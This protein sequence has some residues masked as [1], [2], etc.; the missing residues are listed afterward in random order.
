M[1]RTQSKKVSEMSRGWKKYQYDYHL[2]GKRVRMYRSA[3]G[4]SFADLSL[5]TGINKGT[6]QQ[7]EGKG[8]S[9]PEDDRM[10]LVDVLSEALE[11]TTIRVDRREFLKLAGLGT[12]AILATATSMAPSERN[13]TPVLMRYGSICLELAES[14]IVDLQGE[15]YR[16]KAPDVLKEAQQWYSKLSRAGL[17]ETDPY[18]AAT[19]IRFGILLGRAQE[20]TLPWYQRCKAAIRTYDDVEERIIL[21]FPLNR[22]QVDYAR[23]L[24]LRAPMYRELGQFDESVDQ[25]KDGLSYTERIDNPFLKAALLRDSAHLRAVQ[26]DKT[27]WS[28]A[29]DEALRHTAHVRGPDGERIYSLLKDTQGNGYK[30]LAYNPRI[31]LPESTRRKYAQLALDCF[32]EAQASSVDRWLTD[33]SAVVVDGHP[34]IVSLSIA[35]CLVWIDPYKT[36]EL[37]EKL[38]TKAIRFLPSLLA[39]IDY[40]DYCAKQRLAWRS[41]DPLPVFDLDAK[42]IRGPQQA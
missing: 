17:P 38:R 30:R 6:L 22:F 33:T 40:T 27:S 37:L 1:G 23:L 26:G 34:L 18:I 21:R 42:Y 10:K 9:L 8:R 28:H 24:A 14:R 2:F 35:Q 13:T 7:V 5:R 41:S 39:K 20:A 12:G 15:L 36:L 29:I 25:F 31:S 11:T 4:W 32:K 19:Q 3:L 16:G